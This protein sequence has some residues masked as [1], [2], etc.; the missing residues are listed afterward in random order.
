MSCRRNAF[1]E[2]SRITVIVLRLK[3][4]WLEVSGKK[5]ALSIIKKKVFLTAIL[6]HRIRQFYNCSYQCHPGH[7]HW[8]ANA[9]TWYDPI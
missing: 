6:V 7:G 1:L 3:L 5:I 2:Y 9:V 4:C 8:V